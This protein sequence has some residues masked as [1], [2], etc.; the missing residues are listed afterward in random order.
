MATGRELLEA[1]RDAHFDL[2]LVDWGMPELDGLAAIAELRAAERAA[3]RPRTPIV[4][5]TAGAL[6]DGHARCLAAGA[7]AVVDKPVDL[8]RLAA[9]L[10]RWLRTPADGATAPTETLV[11]AE[12]P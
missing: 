12:I 11:C 2:M 1:A 6:A 10:R 9:V 5:V 3:G 4:V 7:D 8:D